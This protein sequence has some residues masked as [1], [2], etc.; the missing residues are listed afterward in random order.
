MANVHDVAAFILR[1]KGP[2]SAMK[3][4]KLVYYSQAWHLVWEERP[5]FP[6]AV[7]AWANGPV[8]KALYDEHRGRFTITSWPP[9]N[10]DAL[11]AGEA[12]SV[13]AVLGYYG[14]RPAHELSEL[15]HRE[16]PWKNARKGLSAGQRGDRVITHA[17]MAEFYDG[18]T[19]AD[20]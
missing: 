18:L 12:E 5:L 20:V 16:A 8:V 7:Q 13:R 4:Q 15:T 10:P 2:L 1:E 9:G 17:E 11:D 6:E 19:T 14:D 3:L